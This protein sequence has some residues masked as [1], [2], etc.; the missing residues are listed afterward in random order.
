M[1]ERTMCVCNVYGTT[2]DVRKYR[3]CIY[4]IADG[5]DDP[6]ADGAEHCE[7]PQGSEPTDLCPGALERLARFIA[8]GLTPP[9][10]RKKD[11]KAPENA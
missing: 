1:A 2:K 3:V 9:R 11:D 7:C 10:P 8:R 4:E 6:A 5:A